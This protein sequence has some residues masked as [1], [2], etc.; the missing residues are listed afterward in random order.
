VDFEVPEGVS[1][2]VD[3]NT[4]VVVQSPDKALLGETCAKI[5]GFRPPEPYQGKGIKYQ[6]EKIRRKAGKAAG[7]GK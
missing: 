2:K 4:T 1:I 6:G 7:G 5:R 3:G